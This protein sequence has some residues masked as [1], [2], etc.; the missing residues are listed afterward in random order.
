MHRSD[1][2]EDLRILSDS[3]DQWWYAED[4][5][6]SI[7]WRVFFLGLDVA[8]QDGGA[9]HQMLSFRLRG[10]F[11]W[12]YSGG[13]VSREDSYVAPESFVRP[14]RSARAATTAVGDNF[15]SSWG[16]GGWPLLHDRGCIGVALDAIDNIA[17]SIHWDRFP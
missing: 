16:W 7:G 10:V 9:G 3:A 6:E 12:V 14:T 13:L 17:V 8:H 5:A 15:G 4:Y 1:D 11:F 2:Y